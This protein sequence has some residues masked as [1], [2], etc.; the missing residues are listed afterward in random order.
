MNQQRFHKVIDAW[1]GY[2]SE[3]TLISRVNVRMEDG[4]RNGCGPWIFDG[5]IRRSTGRELDGE[6]K[7]RAQHN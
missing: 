6:V 2:Y 7:R 3:T 1:P 5:V 4:Q